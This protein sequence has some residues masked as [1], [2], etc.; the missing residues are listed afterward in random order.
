MPTTEYLSSFNGGELSEYITSR[1]D[2]ET[3]RSGCRTLENMYVLPYGGVTSRTGT[4]YM[5]EALSEN[6]RFI[7]FDFTEDNSYIIEVGVNT[8]DEGKIR[9][10]NGD[11]FTGIEIDSPFTADELK[12]LKYKRIFDVVYIT[13]PT[14]PPQKLSRTNIDPLTFTIAEVDFIYPPLLE[15]NG[16]FNDLIEVQPIPWVTGFDYKTTDQVQEGGIYYICN[17]DHTSTTFAADIANWDVLYAGSINTVTGIEVYVS[18][19]SEQ[20]NIDQEGSTIRLRHQR[21]ESA[22]ADTGTLYDNGNVSKEINVSNVG[23]RISITNN[24]FRGVDATSLIEGNTGGGWSTIASYTG[25]TFVYNSTGLP[26]Q[27]IRVRKTTDA[28]ITT[29]EIGANSNRRVS[30]TGATS[31]FTSD[32]L[33]VS[34]NNWEVSTGD[35]W[36]G[37]V[38]LEKSTD[39]GSTWETEQ[40]ILDTFGADSRNIAVTSTAREG[41]N[42]LIRIKFTRESGTIDININNQSVYSEGLIKL[43]EFIDANTFKGTILN[44][45]GSSAPTKRWTFGAFSADTGYPNA[46]DL[47]E[48]RIVYSGTESD[49]ST[50]WMSV[51]GDYENFQIGSVDDEGIKRIP[52]SAEPTQWLLSRDEL[53]QGSRGGLNNVYPIDS[54]AGISPSNLK[55][56]EISAFGSANIQG[57]FANDVTVYVQRLGKKLRSIVFNDQE[58]SF[59]TQDLT[60]LANHITESGIVELTAQ[61]TPDQIVWLLRND[62]ILAGMT[63]ERDNDIF[64]WHRHD[65]GGEVRTM[66]VRPSSGED[67]LWIAIKR[68]N[69]VYIERTKTREFSDDLLD[70]W[71]VDSG[72]ANELTPMISDADIAITDVTWEVVFTITDHGFSNG[73][74]IRVS[75]CTLDPINNDIFKVINAT[76][77]TFELGGLNGGTIDYNAYFTDGIPEMTGTGDVTEV[78]NVWTGLD[79]LEG[80]I[81][82]V[83][84]DGEFVGDYTVEGGSV[85]I[86]SYQNQTIIGKQF[87]AAIQPMF[88]EPMGGSYNPMGKCKVINTNVIKFYRTVGAVNGTINPKDSTT[89]IPFDSNIFRSDIPEEDKENVDRY[90]SEDVLFRKTSD[91]MGS[92][93]QPFTGDKK[94]YLEDSYNRLK[95]IYIVQSAPL[96]MTVLGM[97]VSITIG[98]GQ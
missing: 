50:I 5:G 24:E 73:D 78:S 84:G 91:P 2:M 17:T 86:D 27:I 98:K 75:D 96:P 90:K 68:N 12:T 47:F 48:E 13:C 6:V 20:F 4:E 36:N 11:G 65:F 92:N 63:Y 60:I 54:S 77:N 3:Y 28:L 19:S 59:N 8:S 57:V 32:P 1:V 30:V 45:L 38:E 79:H 42:T 69:G 70:A 44:T 87:I 76:T 88:I 58:Q 61:K 40:I 41:S 93:I 89:S 16:N 67:E 49:P 97:A 72:V 71:Y 29:Y 21:T 9:I 46:V 80:E 74:I 23:Y 85:T 55:N 62:G 81:V 33:D 51:I 83:Q 37:V 95:S 43:D 10:H 66:G 34:F 64:G 26:N 53:F 22:T 39:G 31:D 35:T 18:S 94:V 56:S 82:Q 25:G 14:K 7:P 52:P 15:E